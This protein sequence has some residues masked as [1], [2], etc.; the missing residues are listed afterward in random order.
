MSPTRDCVQVRALRRAAEIIGGTYGLCGQLDVPHAILVDWLESG[1]VPD[2]YF[3]RAVDIIIGHD[4]R[5]PWTAAEAQ[6]DL[7]ERINTGGR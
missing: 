5:L 2:V 4:H 6:R 1:E 3:L 7:V